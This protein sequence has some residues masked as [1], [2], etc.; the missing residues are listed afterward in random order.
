MLSQFRRLFSFMGIAVLKIIFMFLCNFNGLNWRR[1]LFRCQQQKH[2]NKNKNNQKSK[3]I[4]KKK[5]VFQA[6]LANP[7]SEKLLSFVM[8]II[9]I[10][11]NH[12]L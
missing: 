5:T 10:A 9:N 7:K 6:S 1:P 11:Y 3:K 2:I 8:E 4:N 12:L